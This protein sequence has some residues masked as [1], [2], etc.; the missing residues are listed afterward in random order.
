MVAQR[1]ATLT[2]AVRMVDR[3]HGLAARLRAHAQVTLA[4]GLADRDVL[5]VGVADHADGRA[6][7]REDLA[8]LA[9]R[10]A[11]GGVSALLRHE[12]HADAG[13]ARELAATAGWSS[14]L[15]TS[16]PTGIA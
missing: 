6:A 15:W 11:Q 5:M 12:L 14:T 16:V 10:Q 4:A 7:G 8:H 1:A 9:R 13:R 3:V 2:T